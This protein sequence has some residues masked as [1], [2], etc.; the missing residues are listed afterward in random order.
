MDVTPSE[1]QRAQFPTAFAL[2]RCHA[3]L[4]FLHLKSGWRLPI[5]RMA[6]DVKKNPSV[7][8]NWDSK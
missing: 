5:S 2:D 8:N 1:N 7:C 3:G 4:L 6:N